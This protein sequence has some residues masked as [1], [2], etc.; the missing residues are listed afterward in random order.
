MCSEAITLGSSIKTLFK[1]MYSTDIT[2]ALYAFKNMNH[3]R[4]G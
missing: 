4:D 2:L 3:F 1:E